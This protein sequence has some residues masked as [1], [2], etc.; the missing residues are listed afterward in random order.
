MD[1]VYLLNSPF[2]FQSMEKHS[3]VL[4]ADAARH[5][6]PADRAGAVQEPGRQRALGLHV[7]E[8]QRLLRPGRDRRRHGLP[9]VH[10]AVRR[11]RLARG[12]ADQQ[13]GRPALGLRRVRRDADAPAEV[14]RVRR[15]RPGADDR[16]RD[17]GD[18]LPAGRADAQPVRR[19]PRLPQ[20]VGRAGGGHDHPDGQRVLP[21]GVQL[22][23]DAGPGRRGAAD[24]LR[25]RLPGRRGHL[26]ALLLPV[27]D[28]RA[29]EVVGVLR[30]RPAGAT[31]VD[32]HTER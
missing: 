27:G 3:R 25:Q 31:K 22:L 29:G 5:E 20:P 19:R 26:A 11:R 32:L 23:R 15:V 24:R 4:R 6:D 12:V 7:G 21:L 28:E 1:D 30:W 14:G 16:P 13:R 9:D 8:V 18:A 2:T 17:D 10:E